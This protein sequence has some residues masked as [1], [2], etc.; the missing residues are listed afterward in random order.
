MSQ[1]T[2]AMHRSVLCVDVE[3]FGDQRR[4]D[5][6]QTKVRKGLYQSLRAALAE[7]HVPWESCYREDRGDGALVLIPPE[8]P[9]SDLVTIF[10][11][12]LGAALDRHNQ[13]HG[14]LAQIKLRAALHAGEVRHDAH[15]VVGRPI[16]LAFRLLDAKAVKSALRRSPGVLALA[17]SDWFFNEVIR[18]EPAATPEAYRP[19]RI[20]AKETT[21]DAWVYLPEPGGDTGGARPAKRTHIP[22]QLPAAVHDFVGRDAELA[23]LTRLLGEPGERQAAVVIAVITGPAGVGKTALVVHWAHQVR[24]HFPDG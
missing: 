24:D 11:R 10:P 18:H 5:L 21:T 1:P 23:E 7:S 16:I 17:A 13:E 2:S 14:P 12:A 19:V 9:K 8:F 22:R 15:G 20:I 6:D 4:T 3:N